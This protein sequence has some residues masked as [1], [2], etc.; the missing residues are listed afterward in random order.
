MINRAKIRFACT[1]IVVAARIARRVM[2]II[3]RKRDPG[4]DKPCHY[5]ESEFRNI[6]ALAVLV[7]LLVLP[8]ATSAAEFADV[9]IEAK[10]GRAMEWFYESLRRT[11]ARESI[12]RILH[13]GDSHIAADILT[14]ALRQ[15][16][17]RGFGDAGLG[18]VL[19]GKPWQWYWRK[20][21][22]SYSSKGWRVDGLSQ[23]SLATDNRLGLAG[24]SLSA[25]RAGE[26]VCLEA[27]GARFDLYLMKQ[28]GGGTVDVLLDGA[29]Y[30]HGLSLLSSKPEPLYLEVAAGYDGSHT[31]ELRVASTGWVRIF[32]VVAE[33]DRPGV[34]YDALG[35]NG[36]RADRP[37][38]WDRR[39]LKDNIERRDPDLIV[40]SYGSNEVGDADL[41]L[42]EYGKSFSALLTRLHTAAPRASLLV[43]SPPDRATRAGARWQ[44]INRMSLLVET[45]RQAAFRS[46]AAFWDL[47][48]AMGGA[49]SIE[50]WAT[51]PAPLAQTDRVHLT[52]TG[53]RLVAENLYRQL[54]LAYLWTVI[55]EELGER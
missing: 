29:L 3:A 12:T 9:A 37:L 4:S 31:I 2:T 42:A 30:H 22:S 5:R 36:A 47:F 16:F 18:F 14:G 51:L 48:H 43:I 55:E 6:V 13:Y 8:R 50:R 39:I 33:R 11:E 41:D 53:Y 28:A 25:Y 24:V 46:G 27:A 20:G 19:A 32:G 49:G 15:R 26:W 1:A 35:I 40:I 21:L 23:A 7:A 54:M 34:V 10:D 17:Q 44:T 52:A 45:Q 38:M